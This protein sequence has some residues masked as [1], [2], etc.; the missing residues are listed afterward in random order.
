MKR[1]FAI[2]AILAL[3]LAAGAP[4]AAQRPA[5]RIRWVDGIE[6]PTAGIREGPPSRPAPH[7]PPADVGDVPAFFN[8]Y[9]SSAEVRAFLESLAQEYPGLTALETVGTSWQGRPILGIRLG[10]EAAGDPDARPA[11][12]LDGQHHAREP[13]S[14]LCVLYTLWYLLSQYGRDPLAT[15][16]LDTRTVYAIPSVNPDGNDIW[17]ADNFAQRRNANPTC[18]DDDGDGLVDEDPPNGVGWGTFHAYLYIFDPAWLAEHPDNPFVDD[19]HRHVLGVADMGFVDVQGNPIPQI[20]DD[21][22]NSRRGTNEDPIGGV[23][24]NRNYDVHWNMGASYVWSDVYRGPA[25]WSEPE[26]RAVRDWAR[27]HP[28]IGVAATLHSGAD[29]LLYPWG[30]STGERL[31]DGQVYEHVGRKASQLTECCGFLGTR[32]TWTARGLYVVSGSAMDWLYLQG[33]YA[34]SPE[35]YAASEIASAMPYSAPGIENAY[36]AYTSVGVMFNPSE[37][38]IV[39]ACERWRRFLLYLLAAL[40]APVFNDIA[41]EDGRLIVRVAN[42]GGISADLAL[43]AEADGGPEFQAEAPG[44]RGR[45]F[46]WALP[47]EPLVGRVLTL[48][49]SATLHVGGNSRALPPT[50]LRVRVD[51]GGVE[52]LDGQV[53]PLASLAGFFGEDGWDADPR[54]W[55][56]DYHV[57]PP[58]GFPLVFPMFWR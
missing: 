14:G 52:V 23:D 5:P 11:L 57:G 39:Q 38:R 1:A 2:A 41:V 42:N 19:W 35:V 25:V 49:A 54:R 27:T 58:I 15:H 32:H 4:G 48:T 12:Y 51:E 40:P 21:G 10:N 8:H 55:E 31:P 47:L 46:A 34:F 56:G 7:V 22:D 44:L 18:C 50:T 26:T 28:N 45:P 37:E 9:P 20:D 43:R 16:L 3:V 17:L 29:V 33:I 53:S 36:L 6:D 13:I 24:L 30:W